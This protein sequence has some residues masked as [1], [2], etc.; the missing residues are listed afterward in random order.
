MDLLV[1]TLCDSASDY[2]GKMCLLGTFDTIYAQQLPVAHPQCALA[3]R[4]CFRP[5][6]EGQHSIHV[7][8]IDD[9]GRPVTKEDLPPLNIDVKFPEDSY[10]LTRNLVINIQ[11][12]RFEKAGLYSIDL[13]SGNRILGR[14]PL[15]VMQIQP[16]QRPQTS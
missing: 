10:F 4:I 3:L 11:N 5:E 2:N 15:R 13:H 7:K 9:D 14:I 12:L 1:A 8:F 6:D 16:Q